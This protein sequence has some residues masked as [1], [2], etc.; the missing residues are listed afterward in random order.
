MAKKRIT[1][2]NIINAFLFSAFE[3][4]AGASSLQDISDILQI[5]KASL[6]NHFESK[7]EMYAV[8][9]DYCR[10]Y[11]SNVNFIP[12]ELREKPNLFDDSVQSV[13]KKIIK[14]FINIYEEEPCFQIYSFIHTEQ[15]FNVSAME[16]RKNEIEK[17]EEGFL[18][19]IKGFVEAGKLKKLTPTE[20]R[21]TSAMMAAVVLQQMDLYI[22][23]KKE[24]VRQNPESGV[25]S[26]FALPTD[27]ATMNSI[28]KLFEIYIK[29]LPKN[30]PCE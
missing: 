29:F 19:L 23:Q 25:G 28:I 24:T 21:S 20:L 22:I 1:Q 3:N 7:D 27:D 18:F 13:F 10:M 8:T 5:K 6:Y 26:L 30:E 9:L 16:I 14:R 17:I 2:E 12:D 11:L 4:G 15:Y